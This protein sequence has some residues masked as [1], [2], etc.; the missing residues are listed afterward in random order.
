M[1]MFSKINNQKPDHLAKGEE[2]EKLAEKYLLSKGLKIISNNFNVKG[3]E[4]DRIMMHHDTLVF[5]EV[6]LRE[7]QQV[8]AVESVN[9]HK[10]KRLIK[11]AKM[12][13]LNNVQ[14]HHSP[15]RFDVVAFTKLDS[16]HIDWI[17]DAFQ[18]QEP[19]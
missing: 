18:V 14:Y 6:R 8:T 16:K 13:I 3:G 9:I 7:H 4:I 2:A 12:F 15:C 5:V 17:Q 1:W 10:Q 11:A 19:F